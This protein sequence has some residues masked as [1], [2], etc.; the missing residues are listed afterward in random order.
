M[1]KDK[2]YHDR[3]TM[4][5]GDLLKCKDYCQKMLKLPIGD[6]FTEERTVYEALF[7]AFIVSYGRIFNTSNTVELE[8]KL[9]VSNKFGSFRFKV[10]NN[11]DTNLIKFHDRIIKKRDTAIAH[12]DASSYNYQFNFNNQFPISIGHNPFYPY[13]HDEVKIALELV[14]I[15]ISN[16]GEEQVNIRSKYN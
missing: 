10:I 5:L 12:S 8:Y 1:D 13:G 7:I 15:L 2:H 4:A 14:D 11:L 16:V 9:H 3:L 6:S